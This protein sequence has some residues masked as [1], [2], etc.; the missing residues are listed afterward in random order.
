M[1]CRVPY[2]TVRYNVN[3]WYLVIYTDSDK[4]SNY[5]ANKAHLNALDVGLASSGIMAQDTV[6]QG[7]SD[8]ITK[9]VEDYSGKST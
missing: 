5:N 4:K 8:R 6:Q 2:G 7:E 9:T 3:V 1:P